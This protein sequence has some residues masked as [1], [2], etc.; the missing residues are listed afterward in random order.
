VSNQFRRRR[1]FVFRYVLRPLWRS[2]RIILMAFTCLGPR[3]PP[4]EPRGKTPI[5]QHETGARAGAVRRLK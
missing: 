4:E 5:E 3:M 1:S 2:L